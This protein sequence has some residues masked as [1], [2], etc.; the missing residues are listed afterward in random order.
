MTDVTAANTA[1]CSQLN[2]FV[3]DMSWPAS[4]AAKMETKSNR[5]RISVGVW[6]LEAAW[7]R[8][9]ASN[10]SLIAESKIAAVWSL[11]HRGTAA[12]DCRQIASR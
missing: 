10:I 11:S 6:A 2:R 1:M 3:P 5:M 12:T 8:V 4:N 7:C 9:P